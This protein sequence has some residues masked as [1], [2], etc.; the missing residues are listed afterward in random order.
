M[1]C[2]LEVA[3]V[4]MRY[5]ISEIATI[6]QAKRLRTGDDTVIEQLALDSRRVTET[7]HTLFFA[8][9][10]KRHNGHDYIQELYQKG[11]RNFVVCEDRS[12]G[13]LEG[14][15]IL[16]VKD[17][18]RALQL[19]AAH[20]RAQFS[21]PVIGIT[22]S[23]GK[24][25]VKEWLHQLLEPDYNI[26][27]SPKSY[28]SQVGVPLSVW[29]MGPQHT[30]GIF[31]AGISESGEMENLAKVIAPNIG[32]FTNIGEAH[33]EGF[34]NN[35][36]KVK[37]KLKLFINSD[38][39]IYC[40]DYHDITQ[41]ITEYR[42]LFQHEDE[43]N[44][45][46]D[47][48]TWAR[49]T[50]ADLRIKY[51]TKGRSDTQIT[52]IFKDTELSI[53]VPF[54]DDA[55]IENAINCW[56]MLLYLEV[57]QAVIDQ[58]MHKLGKI[59]MRLELKDAI[60]NCSLI[61]DSYNS[62][63]GSLGIA[64]DFL[65]QQQ[66]HEKHTVILSDILQSGKASHELYGQVAKLLEEKGVHRLIAIGQ[67]LNREK[68]RLEK[69]V[70]ESIFYTDTQ[71]FLKA[72]PKLKFDNEVIL[73]KGARSFEFE[74]ISKLLEEKVHE[75]VLE[76]NLNALANNLQ[77][78]HS[79]L[80]PGTKMMVMVKAFSY[81][82]GSFEIANALQYHRADYLGVAYADE[83]VALRQAGIKLP[84]MVM[85]P[86]Q[87]SFDT[88]I[89]YE[90]EPDIYSITLLR[91]FLQAVESAGIEKEGG[92]PV[93]IEVDT[94]MKR[95]GFEEDDLPELLRLLKEY[96]SL[97]VQ[98]VFSHMTASDESIHDD[99]TRQQIQRF[100]QM[101]GQIS[102][103]LGYQP[104]RHI[105]NSAGIV[106]FPEAHFEMVRLG[107][108]LYGIDTSEALQ[109]KLQ[110]VGRLKTTISQ[111]KHVAAGDTIG[112]SRKWK[113]SQDMRIATLGIGYADG[114]DRRL[115]NG[116]GKMLIHGKLAPIVGN[117]CM[118]MCMLDVTS[119][120]EAKEGDEVI[121]F[122]PEL[123]VQDIATWIDTIPYE[124]L[125]GISERVKRVYFHE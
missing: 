122:G 80:Q 13:A 85:N 43:A 18:V 44:S 66:Q 40:R 91:E 109:K 79:H 119:I 78:Y 98:S 46:F 14:A 95:L 76:I 82:S 5:T 96:P 110:T 71:S 1:V 53:Q 97:K 88:I 31:E 20:H 120:P 101:S 69:V 50:D 2:F 41:A 72:F 73:L 6:I 93:H 123:T 28:N 84:V 22:G 90:L 23:N 117:V 48:F 124:I 8:V 15:N 24:T 125:T 99:F 86:E 56:A 118:D 106:R 108:G 34:L 121:I 33:S 58:R 102:A 87:H 52:G 116:V 38:V 49:N 83:G 81:G 94:G 70:P 59:A 67:D 100:E 54:T 68:I 62:D 51:T 42:G 115:S 4:S 30:L 9:P 12:F 113:A 16:L 104:I 107:L 112:Y 114:I 36:H 47:L 21:Y 27:R 89:Q 7:G 60:H 92:F 35:R 25:I 19:L 57:P 45:T 77:V 29:Q 63:L 37:E 17:S 32:L 55:S 64:L 11:N 105:V 61:N 39:V 75:T 3:T 103:T 65:N 111:I 74:K 10:G 26:V